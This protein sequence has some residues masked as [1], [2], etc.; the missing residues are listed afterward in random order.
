VLLVLARH[1]VPLEEQELGAQ[2]ADALGAVRERDGHV[3]R[4]A[5]VRDDLDGMPVARQGRL[6]GAGASLAGRLL[7]HAASPLVVGHEL[8]GR[9]DEDDTHVPV[10]KQRGVLG[11]LQQRLAQPDRGRDPERARENRAVR[12]RA[13]GGGGDPVRELPVESGRVR[14]SQVCGDHDPGTGQGGSARIAGQGSDNLVCHARQV[15]GASRQ[16][17]VVKAAVV[18]GDGLGRRMPGLGRV[19]PLLEDRASGRPQQRIVVEEEQM[20]VE[21]GRAVLAGSGF[22]R[23]PRGADLGADVLECSFERLPLRLGVAG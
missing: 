18:G 8:V 3:A 5:D 23:L 16:I 21:D 14:G 20:G 4:R 13:A 9:L 7:S 12:G 19:P 10:E 22:D 2:Q 11:N 17:V 1:R 6:G 15:L